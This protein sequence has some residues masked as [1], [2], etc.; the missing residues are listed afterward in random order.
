MQAVVRGHA[1]V[2]EH[3]V[4]RGHAAVYEHAVVRGH[5]AVYEHAVVRGHAAV[6]EHGHEREPMYGH[7]PVY[8]H[9]AVRGQAGVV[10]PWQA[11]VLDGWR[12]GVVVG[13]W[14]PPPVRGRRRLGTRPA[15]VAIFMAAL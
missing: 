10:V 2:Y 7:E 14:T 15:A 6:Y 3:A 8:E 1:A 5:A 13:R 4:V 12:T 9:A 11:V